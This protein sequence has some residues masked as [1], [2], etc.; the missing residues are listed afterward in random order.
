V[1][2]GIIDLSSTTIITFIPDAVLPFLH[3]NNQCTALSNCASFFIRAIVFFFVLSVMLIFFPEGRNESS[4]SLNW[5]QRANLT[6][7]KAGTDDA[8]KRKEKV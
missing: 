3:I 2:L 5:F 8:L 1:F 6:S 7:A 4:L